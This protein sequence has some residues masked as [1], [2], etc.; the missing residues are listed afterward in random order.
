MFFRDQERGNKISVA[1]N[2][3]I[4]KSK[5]KIKDLTDFS[6]G[7]WE[8]TFDSELWKNNEILNLFVENVEQGDGETLKELK[9][10]KVSVLQW[11]IK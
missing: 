9:G 7:L 10:Q 3:D 8:P 2:S 11:K 5:W 1:I 6:V 4:R